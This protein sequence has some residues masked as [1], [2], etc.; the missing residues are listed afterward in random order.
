MPDFV[1]EV[2]VPNGT[3]TYTY[4]KR[5]E[6]KN[7]EKL[8]SALDMPKMVISISGPSKTGKTALVDTLITSDR[9]IPVTGQSLQSS[10]E[11]WQSV[12]RWIG[13]PEEI[14]KV[15]E[16]L[17]PKLAITGILATMYDHR[18]LH[19]RE[20]MAR[21]VEAFGEIVFD[22]VINRTVRFPETTVAGEPI[23]RWAPRSSGAQAYRALAREVIAR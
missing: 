7:E 21:V 12:M 14:E 8:A 11:L 17:N 1:F 23:T 22:T 5:T 10:N 13:G 2:F 3:P 4:V 15:K 20:V 6:E 16:R 9:I 18:T 19:S